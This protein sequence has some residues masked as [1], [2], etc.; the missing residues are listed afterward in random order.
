MRL[1]GDGRREGFDLAAWMKA[2]RQRTDRGR[3]VAPAL[4]SSGIT[5]G[6][7]RLP[8]RP[9]VGGGRDAGLGGDGG[10]RD[11]AWQRGC[12]IPRALPGAARPCRAEGP[13][14]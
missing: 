5:A 11:S 7:A 8:A 4:R 6:P 3:L 1:G 14:A 13:V 12:C 2:A 9:L 10:G